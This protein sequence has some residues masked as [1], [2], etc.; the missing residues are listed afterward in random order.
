[1]TSTYQ[2]PSEQTELS[3]LAKVRGAAALSWGRLWMMG[4]VLFGVTM[5]LG[6]ALELWLASTIVRLLTIYQYG[7]IPAELLPA[8]GQTIDTI[9]FVTSVVGG[10]GIII[11]LFVSMR[12][13]RT[14]QERVSVTG[15]EY[16][17]FWTV[18]TILVPIA[19]LFR[20]WLGLAEIRRVAYVG[21]LTG[22]A[23]GAWEEGAPTS[24]ATIGLAIWFILGGAA[25]RGL[26]NTL[27]A[28]ENVSADN[29]VF[30][31]SKYAAFQKIYLCYA[32]GLTAIFGAYCYTA[33][34]RT[35]RFLFWRQTA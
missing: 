8:H 27:P 33:L 21:S 14:A 5:L 2:P 16:S 3:D 18:A 29:A 9:Y 23:Y 7:H 25:L 22:S 19:N 20:P 15:Y 4:A 17:F 26:A 35:E 32:L 12:C 28:I 6:A 31:F 24:W 11:C 1:M 30:I 13:A 34:K 10:L